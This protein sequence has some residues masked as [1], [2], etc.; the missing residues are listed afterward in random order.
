VLE[1]SVRK[2]EDRIR[3]T[4]QLIDAATGHH[5]WSEKYDRNLKD[6]FNLQEEIT[7]QILVSLQVTLTEGDQARLWGGGTRNLEAYMKQ[8][9]GREHFLRFTVEDNFRSR[10]LR[11]EALALDSEYPRAIVGLAWTHLG[12]ILLGSSASRDESLQKAEEL[13]QKALILDPDLPAVYILYGYIC[14]IKGQHEKAIAY[15]EKALALSPNGAEVHAALG[16]FLI[17]AGRPEESIPYF[18]KAF[19]L[20]PFPPSWYYHWLGDAYRMLERYDDALAEYE[21]ATQ[22]QPNS[23]FAIVR[24]AAMYSALNR[25]NEARERAE[26]ILSL[27]PKFSAEHFINDLPFKNQVQKDRYLEWLH[28]AGLN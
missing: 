11:E 15:G 10:Q 21:K 16:M 17:G 20:N 24:Q 7:K 19:R 13:A 2:T 1:G 9:V 26:K 23:L 12:D 28:R 25:E 14:R 4:A 8:T 27:N 6:I 3:I 18:E 22:V 5:L